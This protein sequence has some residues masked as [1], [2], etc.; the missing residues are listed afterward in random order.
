MGAKRSHDEMEGSGPDEEKSGNQGSGEQE[1]SVE[2]G[3]PS[4]YSINSQVIINRGGAN[5]FQ[6]SRAAN[7]RTQSWKD[8]NPNEW[9][10]VKVLSIGGFEM[11][12]L[13]KYME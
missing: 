5:G 2:D 4:N 12:R 11:D 10:G 13:L 3:N 8:L 9:K 6:F 7:R 1:E